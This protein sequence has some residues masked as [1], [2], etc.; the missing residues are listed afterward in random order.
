MNS[1]GKYD[2][3]LSYVLYVTERGLSRFFLGNT[4]YYDTQVNADYYCTTMM[5]QA[6]AERTTYC[7][8]FR[9]ILH[10]NPPGLL[11]LLAHELRG[12]ARSELLTLLIEHTEE[13]VLR[14]RLSLVIPLLLV[15]R[16]LVRLVELES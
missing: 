3:Y 1:K 14:G 12:D 9:F 5:L 16:H 4:A 10:C 2:Y 7:S 13:T 11:A 15:V 6:R 8:P